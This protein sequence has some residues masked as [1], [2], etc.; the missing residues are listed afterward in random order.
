MSASSVASSTLS[1]SRATV[2]TIA[3]LAAA[4]GSYYAYI[5]NYSHSES[6]PNTSLHRSNAIH[7]RRRRNTTTR[8]DA[9]SL[10]EDDSGENDDSSGLPNPP[11]ILPL[12]DGETVVDESTF[13][14]DY[15]W[16]DAQTQQSYQ[17]SGQNIV[18]LLF[19]VSEDATRRN[20]YVHRGCAC[21]GCGVV[22]IRGIRYRCANCS[23][24]DLCEGCES[25]GLHIKTHIFYK[26]RVPTPSFGPRHLQ[27]V[28]YTGDPDSMM[29]VLPKELILMLS[30]ETGFERPEIDAYWEQWTF[31][32]NTDWRDDPDDIGLAMDRRTFERCLVPSGGYRHPAPSLIFDRM[33]SFYDTNK[34]N[35]IS[36]PEFLHGLAYR[37]KKDKWKKIFEGYDIDGDGFVDRKDFLR[38]FRSYYVLYRQMH[39]DMLD[40]MD[41]QQMSTTEAHRLVS[42][43]QPL[44]SAFGHDGRYPPAPDPRTGEGKTVQPNGDLEITDGKGVINESGDDTGDREDVFKRALPGGN[45]WRERNVNNGAYWD[46]M[47]NPP[48]SIE[49]MPDVIAN[50]TRR[51]RV[52]TSRRQRAEFVGMFTNSHPVLAMADQEN[53]EDNDSHSESEEEKPTDDD[54]KWPPRFVNVTDEDAEAVDGPGT[55]VADV[56]RSS[57]PFVLAHAVERERTQRTIYERWKRRQFYT[58]EEEGATP[59]ANWNEDDDV[60]AQTGNAGES[61]NPQSRP[62]YHSRSSSRVRFAEDMDDFDTR[63]NPSTSSRSVPERWGGMEIPDVE[64]DAGKEILYQVTQ[65]SFNE[66]LD[67]LFKAKEDLALE[68]AE[69]KLDRER[70]GQLFTTPE[71][72]Q[73]A[74]RKEAEQEKKQDSPGRPPLPPTSRQPVW[75]S[76]PEV[77]VEEVRERPLEELLE[78][79]GYSIGSGPTLA[80]PQHAPSS[81]TPEIE[82][83]VGTN[84]PPPSGP[85]TSPTSALSIIA[86]YDDGPGEHIHSPH[87]TPQATPP[88]PASLSS[89]PA[90]YRDPT[91]PQFRPNATQPRQTTP[92]AGRTPRFQ[93]HIN[94]FPPSPAPPANKP[95]DPAHSTP[96]SSRDGI[97][98]TLENDPAQDKDYLFKLWKCDQAE[99]E[100]EVRGGWGRLGFEEFE[101]VVRQYRRE[102]ERGNQMDYLGSWIEFCIP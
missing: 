24:Y 47:L 41:D 93:E 20:A 15:S 49:Q 8:E 1:R 12:T 44:S 2:L 97:P 36:F 31:M 87:S 30:R 82:A 6:S 56:H 95:V 54:S 34:D 3:V 89:E 39:R 62:T 53:E 102:E 16:N 9:T 79:T 66:L 65:Q 42:G 32:A 37:K 80:E 63:S 59:P 98:V 91:L 38:M 58:D 74:I 19:R 73:W 50:L 14:D 23:D 86:Q 67:P 29:R 78:A 71:F 60:L 81:H 27:P 4:C 92:V 68:A 77:E 40:G 69:T 96:K 33:F 18:Q 55:R 10:F 26:I 51:R 101:N 52:R 88:S 21:N 64:K 76:F 100:K 28:W 90:S 43:R 57:R 48:M 85:P 25:Q 61:S 45:L 22:P 72:E 46:A 11:D 84:L 70:Y 94:S 17:R 83:I 13:Q 75:P 7:R 5:S 99:R 35:K